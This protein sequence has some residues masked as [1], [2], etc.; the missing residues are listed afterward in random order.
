MRWHGIL[1]S[2]QQQTLDYVKSSISIILHQLARPPHADCLSEKPQCEHV[3]TA[4]QFSPT[5]RFDS[6]RHVCDSPQSRYKVSKE[7]QSPI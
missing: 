1:F 4:G 5:I 2:K 3:L 7:L 6:I